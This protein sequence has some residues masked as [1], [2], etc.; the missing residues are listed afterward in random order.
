MPLSNQYRL[1]FQAK[2]GHVRTDVIVDQ[3]F[4]FGVF[5]GDF[6]DDAMGVQILA[7]CMNHATGSNS[8]A[9]C[10]AEVILLTASCNTNPGNLA[11]V[12]DGNGCA[13]L[14]RRDTIFELAIVHIRV[15][16]GHMIF[17]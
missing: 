3:C 10:A 17:L 8:A 13:A 15:T 16:C 4:D 6:Q 11:V 9:R 12:G 5:A 2:L 14:T 1:L 7:F